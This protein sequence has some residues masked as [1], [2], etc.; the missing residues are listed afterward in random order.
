MDTLETVGGL[1]DRLIP[2]QIVPPQDH[3][4]L[5][6]FIPTFARN[7]LNTMPQSVYEQRYVYRPQGNTIWVTAP[8]IVERLLLTESHNIGK[9]KLER[10]VFEQSLGDGILTS[11]G[12]SW[13]WQRR[14]AAPLFRHADLLALI[15]A[16]VAA[17]EEQAA[18]WAAKP[19][20]T[21]Q[22]IDQDMEAVTFNIISRTIF[23][24]GADTEGDAIR[25]HADV[26]LDN[27]PWRILTAIFNAPGWMWYPGKYK[28][29]RSA[30]AI[31]AAVATILER[32]RASG[33]DGATDITA[34]LIQARDP[35]TGAP[36]SDAQ[37]IDNL[38]TFLAAG[39]ETTAKAL[40]W[41]LYLLARAPDWQERVRDEVDR[42]A[43]GASLTA[44]HLDQLVITRQVVKEAMRLYPPA[45]MMSR[46][47]AGPSLSRAKNGQMVALSE[48]TPFRIDDFDLPPHTH[49]VIPIYAIHRH[50]ALWD[51]P[52][53]FDPARF[54][55]E[56]EAQ[57][58]RT[59]FMPFGFGPRIC[60]GM[61][62]AMMEAVLLLATFVR[63]ARFDWDGVHAP[64]PVSRIT[65][66]PRGGMPLLV[67]P[68]KKCL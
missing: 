28:T 43:G 41:T 46:V 68:R 38:L 21:V 47:T 58:A 54:S 30:T 34:R 6:K 51:N 7:P 23:A 9:T 24:G 65:L 50:L 3:L 56:R 2:P 5:W 33:T 17:A 37:L 53:R 55:A 52:E 13:K 66:R 27:T 62:F 35:E 4:P 32:R 11:Q 25:H 1:D 45:P 39:H 42:I 60:I 8:D 22:A 40:T 61:S 26:L 64:E 20:G 16:M 49:I 10:R 59:Q 36:M 18:Q 57:H 63:A 15:P 12:A 67:T 48:Q 14:T 19:S 29:R 44:A 31:R